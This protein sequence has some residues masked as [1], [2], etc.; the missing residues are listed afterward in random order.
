MEFILGAMF[1]LFYRSSY[2]Q[3]FSIQEIQDFL[4]L[5]KGLFMGENPLAE[6]LENHNL[7]STEFFQLPNMSHSNYPISHVLFLMHFDIN[8]IMCSGCD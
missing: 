7:C 6:G 8:K 3:V 1:S 2:L 4:G 5:L